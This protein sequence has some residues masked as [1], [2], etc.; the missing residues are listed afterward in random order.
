M[1]VF[2]KSGPPLYREVRT[3]AND[4]VINSS[5]SLFDIA[6]TGLLLNALGRLLQKFTAAEDF[7][8]VRK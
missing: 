2:K 5:V 6:K 7:L 4:M 8:Y 1:G 3:Q